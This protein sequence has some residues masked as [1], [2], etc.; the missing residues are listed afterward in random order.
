MLVSHQQKCIQTLFCDVNLFIHIFENF[1]QL[2]LN[3]SHQVSQKSSYRLIYSKFDSK[4]VMYSTR[5]TWEIPVYVHFD[6]KIYCIILSLKWGC[7]RDGTNVT[8]RRNGTR[9][10]IPRFFMDNTYGLFSNGMV[11]VRNGTRRMR[12][13]V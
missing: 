11:M 2:I 9:F 5:H 10:F 8:V 12:F 7:I 4:R 6:H 1:P 3:F 13:F